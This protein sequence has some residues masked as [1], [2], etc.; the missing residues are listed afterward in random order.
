MTARLDDLT[1]GASV[2]GLVPGESVTVVAA[3]WHGESVMTLTYRRT[4]GEVGSELVYRADEA[5]LDLD[6]TGEAWAV[7]A[8]GLCSGSPPRPVASAWPTCSTR[9]WLST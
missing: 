8:D 3:E 4:T 7:D 6:A 1:P 2:R 5:R 9:A